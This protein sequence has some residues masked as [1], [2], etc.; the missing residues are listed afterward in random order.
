MKLAVFV[1]LFA[2][3]FSSYAK[4]FQAD[5]AVEEL[6]DYIRGSRFRNTNTRQTSNNPRRMAK[7][8]IKRKMCVRKHGREDCDRNGNVIVRKIVNAPVKNTNRT[9]KKKVV[10]MRRSR[11]R[12]TNTR[13]TSNNP[14]RT[15]GSNLMR[16]ES[17]NQSRYTQVPTDKTFVQHFYGMAQNNNCAKL[18]HYSLAKKMVKSGNY[19]SSWVK[20]L[21]AAYDDLGKCLSGL[22]GKKKA[23]EKKHGKKN[24][25]KN[26]NVI[27][28]ETISPEEKKKLEKVE[29]IVKKI[30][31][32][33]KNILLNT[34]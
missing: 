24:C 34:L 1:V 29:E 14:R 2:V 13:Q 5:A 27:V 11:F 23:C 25:D 32:A 26:G 21:K 10:V 16:R 18:E 19:D 31:P 7:L 28:K 17:P 8:D 33:L 3:C 15:S 30:V 22:K 20:T 12:N 4:G 6:S 9:K